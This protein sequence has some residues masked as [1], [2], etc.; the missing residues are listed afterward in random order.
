MLL[1]ASWLSLSCHAFVPNTG[2]ARTTTRTARSIP[3][4]PALP[5]PPSSSRLALAPP[6][7]ETSN[8][9]ESLFSNTGNVPIWQA[10]GI[11]A[12]LFG[13]LR[14]KLLNSLTPEGFA[15]SFALAVL[16]WT[17]LGWKGW[18][19]AVLYL[20]CGNIVTKVKFEEK[21]A[22]GLAEGRGGRRGPENVW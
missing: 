4:G 14:K 19:F 10:A 9:V 15:H 17:T 13:S 2:L 8:L 16:L 1:V 7:V 6:D 22:Q 20:I 11:N 3:T 12:V 21:E 5:S 18:T